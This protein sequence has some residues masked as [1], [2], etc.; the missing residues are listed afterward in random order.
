MENNFQ[1]SNAGQS[2][3]IVALISAAL[4]IIIAFIPCLNIFA[5]FGGIIAIIFASVGLSQAKAENAPTALANT[6]L[7]LGIIAVILSVI[8]VLVGGLLMGLLVMWN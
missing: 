2:M 7:F 1:R 4:S 6:G 5:V 3:S 8:F